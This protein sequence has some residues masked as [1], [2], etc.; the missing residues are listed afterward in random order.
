MSLIVCC[1]CLFYVRFIHNFETLVFVPVLRFSHKS[2]VG[3]FET[4]MCRGSLNEIYE[5]KK[6]YF[7]VFVF[8]GATINYHVSQLQASGTTRE[9]NWCSWMEKYGKLKTNKQLG[10]WSSRVSKRFFSGTKSS[11][12]SGSLK[13]FWP[14]ISFRGLLKASKNWFDF[15]MNF[16][17]CSSSTTKLYLNILLTNS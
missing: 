2:R 5:W 16:L 1:F 9:D 8:L 11:V 6:A 14:K 13:R 17:F 7:V 15:W 12:E 10:V 4:I 3:G